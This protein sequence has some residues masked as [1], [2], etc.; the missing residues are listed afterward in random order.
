MV[1]TKANEPAQP[2]EQASLPPP[3]QPAAS[4][5]RLPPPP[6]RPAP[7]EPKMSPPPPRIRAAELNLPLPIPPPPPPVKDSGPAVPPPPP[8]QT[9]KAPEPALPL[10]PPP[11]VNIPEPPLPPPPAPVGVPP[12]SERKLREYRYRTRILKSIFLPL[13]FSVMSFW[14][15]YNYVNNFE[16]YY[17][18]NFPTIIAGF[19]TGAIVMNGFVMANM[20][21]ARKRGTISTRQ[22]NG[23][24]IILAFLVPYL[25]LI[26][27]VSPAEAWRFSIGYFFSAIMTPMVVMVYESFANGKFFIQEEEVEDRLTRTLVFRS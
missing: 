17:T 25:Y 12:V 8:E 11:P 1:T 20:W 13:M 14:M 2:A 15:L 16:P 21:A 22:R 19:L 23:A 6:P 4:E 24:V 5:A 9:A 7:S 10:P 3:P 18:W 27:L 26:L